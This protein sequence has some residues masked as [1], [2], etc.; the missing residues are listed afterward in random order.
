MNTPQQTLTS[1][2]NKK[3]IHHQPFPSQVD[4]PSPAGWTFVHHAPNGGG[5]S[6]EDNITNTLPDRTTH[7][8]AL[9]NA[10]SEGYWRI[11]TRNIVARRAAKARVSKQ[12]YRYIHIC[13]YII[14]INQV[15]H[16]IFDLKRETLQALG[17]VQLQA[18]QIH[19]KCSIAFLYPRN[20]V[21]ANLRQFEDAIATKVHEKAR[22]TRDFGYY[23]FSRCNVW[24]RFKKV[25]APLHAYTYTY[26]YMR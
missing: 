14:I 13:V 16:V 21:V 15:T 6:M 22:R 20:R 4:W 1:A 7:T 24:F 3:N 26:T 8:K 18:T 5:W 17:C 23:L 2:N 19:L 10:I 9:R 11:W 12:I 25:Q